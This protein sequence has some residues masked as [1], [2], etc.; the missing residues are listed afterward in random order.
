MG[1]RKTGRP[2]FLC[3]IKNTGAWLLARRPI[4]CYMEVVRTF[5][6]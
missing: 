5:F 2:F 3:L 4:I 6:R 1:V